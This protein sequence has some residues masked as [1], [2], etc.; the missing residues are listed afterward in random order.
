MRHVVI[1]GDF[2][3]TVECF[4]T[5][6]NPRNEIIEKVVSLCLCVIPRWILKNMASKNSTGGG[7]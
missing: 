3:S 4:I 2:S 7:D 5:C 6:E 1:G